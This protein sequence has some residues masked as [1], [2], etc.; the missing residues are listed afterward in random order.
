MAFDQN[1]LPKPAK[2]VSDFLF[3][4]TDF[5]VTR[6][7]ANIC[8][9]QLETVRFDDVSSPSGAMPIYGCHGSISSPQAGFV[10]FPQLLKKRV[11]SHGDF[12]LPSR[13][14]GQYLSG[15]SDTFRHRF[16]G[17]RKIEISLKLN[18]RAEDPAC[19][20]LTK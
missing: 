19:H 15:F 5:R 13:E 3:F 2:K 17:N 1:T 16:V 12:P 10:F 18:G 7:W 6:R 20:G 11:I 9:G 8:C 14:R 4:L